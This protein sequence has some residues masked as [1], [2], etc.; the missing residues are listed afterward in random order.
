MASISNNLKRH[1]RHSR[2]REREPTVELFE[3]NIKDKQSDVHQFIRHLIFYNGVSHYRFL[4][5][6]MAYDWLTDN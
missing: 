3:T 5:G 2:P 4:S 1:G 6:V